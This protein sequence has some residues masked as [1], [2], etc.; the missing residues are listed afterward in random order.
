VKTIKILGK[1]IKGRLFFCVFHLCFILRHEPDRA[2]KETKLK[3]QHELNNGNGDGPVNVD[4]PPRRK[5]E[6][7]KGR[8]RKPEGCNTN[9]DP[10]FEEVKKMK[11]AHQ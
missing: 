4:R 6:K 7:E 3:D 10:F 1:N 2:F 11:E 9:D 8:V 5:A